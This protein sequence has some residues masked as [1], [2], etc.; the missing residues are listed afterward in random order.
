MNRTRSQH[1]QYSDNRRA[2]AGQLRIRQ[3]PQNVRIDA[4]EL[5]QKTRDAGQDEILSHDRT[6]AHAVQL[7]RGALPQPCGNQ[8]SNNA[9]IEWRGVDAHSRRRGIESIGEGHG[10][11][12]MTGNAVIAVTAGQAAD[13]TDGVTNR[14]SRRGKIERLQRGQSN[15]APLHDQRKNA[16]DQSAK[17]GES[18]RSPKHRP[19]RGAEIG[20]RI[21]DVPKLGSDDAGDHGHGHNAHGIGWLA[22]AIQN[23]RAA[24]TEM[25]HHRTA[26]GRHPQHQPK[27]GNIPRTHAEEMSAK[28]ESKVKSDVQIRQHTQQV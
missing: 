13:A 9:L 6:R 26:H 18:T 20:R 12:K 15:G 19:A 21:E 7:L 17:P 24:K 14:R 22:L 1:Q 5:H 2:Y 28:V 10:P 27:G 11:G 25:E 4:D 3:S 23:V 8:Q 16:S